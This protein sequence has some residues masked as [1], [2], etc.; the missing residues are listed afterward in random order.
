MYIKFF[1]YYLPPTIIIFVTMMHLTYLFVVYE[2]FADD[3]DSAGIQINTPFMTNI[4]KFSSVVFSLHD[5]RKKDEE[6]KIKYH[7]LQF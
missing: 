5:G 2:S 4:A 6:I 1:R 7:K 3:Y